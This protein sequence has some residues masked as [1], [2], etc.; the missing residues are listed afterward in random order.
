LKSFLNAGRKVSSRQRCR[1]LC[2]RYAKPTYGGIPCKKIIDEAYG[3]RSA[4]SHGTKTDFSDSPCAQYMRLIALD[5][6]EG[7]MKEREG[8]FE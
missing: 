2:A 8:Q 5:V 7:Y 4:F 6:V 1:D 3:L